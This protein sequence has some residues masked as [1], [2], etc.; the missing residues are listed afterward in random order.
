MANAPTKPPRAAKRDAPPAPAAPRASEP[1][2]KRHLEA[3]SALAVIFG[4]VLGLWQ[5]FEARRDRRVDATLAFAQRFSDEK[6]GD[7]RRSLDALWLARPAEIAQ[8]RALGADAQ[9]QA[10]LTFKQNFILTGSSETP[11]RKVMTAIAEIADFLDQL[12]LCV[13]SG[14]CDRA[15]AAE[16]F[17]RYAENFGELYA[18]DLDGIHKTAGHDRLGAGLKAFAEGET[19]TVPAGLWRW[20]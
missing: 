7:Y 11:P 9:G 16:Y 14:R 1:S 12:G 20:F 5:L 17:C 6:I 4:V 3:L 8:I 13:A 15:I 18:S 19:C 2:W 10:L